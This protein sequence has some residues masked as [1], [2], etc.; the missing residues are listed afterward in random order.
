MADLWPGDLGAAAAE[1]T[2]L[3]LFVVCVVL[4]ALLV[5]HTARTAVH[6]RVWLATGAAVLV[7]AAFTTPALGTLWFVAFPLLASVFPDGRFVPRWT[8]VPVVLCVVPATIEL[9]SPGAWSDQPW[10]TYFAVSQLLFLA[11]QVHRYRRRATTEERESVR[12][13]IL[14]TLVTMACYAAIAAAWG[15]DVGEES[16]WSLAASNLA[17]LPIA[18]GVAAGVVRPGGLDVDR[19][20]HLTVA[21]WVGVPVLAATYAVPSTLLGGWWGA[22]AVGAVAWPVGLLGRRVADWVVYR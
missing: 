3:T 20:L 2:Y 10:W 14:G 7:L 9:V 1:A 5:I 11:A 16:D 8:V 12:W 4:A 15:G 17:L 22:A 6:R 19:A 13:I 21:G 18:L